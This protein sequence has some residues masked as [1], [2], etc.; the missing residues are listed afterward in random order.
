M[1]F[2][3]I[4]ALTSFVDAL[5]TAGTELGQLEETDR[6]A[7]GAVVLAGRSRTP[8]RTGRLAST[9]QV[10]TAGVIASQ[11]SYAAPVH[12]GWQRGR[13]RV[14]GRPWLLETADRIRPDLEQL[15]AD[16]IDTTLERI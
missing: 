5:G 10:T 1:A 2:L 8:R 7:A 14:A 13:A 6:A 4:P 9:T 11:A 15:Y 12:W 16:H 3:E